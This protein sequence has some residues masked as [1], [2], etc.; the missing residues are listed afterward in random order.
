M[1]F[2]YGYVACSYPLNKIQLY[3]NIRT[4]LCKTMFLSLPFDAI[5]LHVFDFPSLP[6]KCF[7]LILYMYLQNTFTKY[8]ARA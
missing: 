7:A 4:D 3:K 6:F 5:N 2:G 1:L 8:L